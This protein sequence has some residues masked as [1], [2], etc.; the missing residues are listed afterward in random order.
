[1]AWAL[2]SSHSQGYLQAVPQLK[3]LV[4]D[5]S[6]LSGGQKTKQRLKPRLSQDLLQGCFPRLLPKAGLGR[7]SPRRAP[8]VDFLRAVKP[9]AG[10][11][12]Y[13]P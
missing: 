6:S 1:M 9:V 12:L 4:P 8:L 13:Y 11:G 2:H 10:E 3:S 5:V 7:L